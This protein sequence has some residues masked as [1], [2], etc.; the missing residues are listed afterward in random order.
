MEMP[1]VILQHRYACLVSLFFVSM[2]GNALVAQ[3]LNKTGL[4]NFNVLSYHMFFQPFVFGYIARHALV[5]VAIY[6]CA[7]FLIAWMSITLLT[8]RASVLGWILL[9]F[10]VVSLIPIFD[11]SKIFI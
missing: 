4:I 1:K 2:L 5:A 3:L 10:Y 11:Y 9:V 6:A 8:T 7:N